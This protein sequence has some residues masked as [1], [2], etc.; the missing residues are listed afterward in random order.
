MA[1]TARAVVIDDF[2]AGAQGATASFELLDLSQAGL[3]TGNV[4]GGVRGVELW[5][6]G[7]VTSLE[8]DTSGEGKAVFEVTSGNGG[9]LTLTYGSAEQPLNLDLAALGH[10]AIQIRYRLTD[11]NPLLFGLS[12]YR[13]YS[14]GVVSGRSIDLL[15]DNTAGPGVVELVRPISIYNDLSDI[16]RIDFAIGRVPPGTRLEILELATVPTL[17]G[18]LNLDGFVGVADL[19]IVL[20]RW[21]QSTGAGLRM[22][23]DPTGDGFVGIEDLN[24]VLGNWNAGTPA[25]PPTASTNIPEPTACAVVLLGAGVWLGR[26]RLSAD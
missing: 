25:T 6:N 15:I 19:N 12:G 24:T 21:N 18:D 5:G 2:T 13:V 26:G 10:D 4:I 7:G 20:A 23:G 3:P 14:S 16:D 8:I 22:Q 17:T 11:A 1:G 9:Y